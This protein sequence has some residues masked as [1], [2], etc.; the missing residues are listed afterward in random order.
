MF[1]VQLISLGL[2]LG[3]LLADN[4]RNVTFD[5]IIQFMIMSIMLEFS[6]MGNSG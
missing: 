3:F 4:N 5:V 6:N 1:M 2:T